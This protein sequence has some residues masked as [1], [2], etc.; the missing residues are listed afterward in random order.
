VV[1]TV[2]IERHDGVVDAAGGEDVAKYLG[3][4][5]MAAMAALAGL[6]LVAAGCSREGDG[7][8]TSGQTNTSAQAPAAPAADNTVKANATGVK[9][10]GPYSDANLTAPPDATKGGVFGP[11]YAPDNSTQG[12]NQTAPQ[13]K[14]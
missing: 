10:K 14:Q 7:A 12:A 1:E 13:Q 2:A 3:V 5:R 8:E 9:P 4:A 11:D 6:G